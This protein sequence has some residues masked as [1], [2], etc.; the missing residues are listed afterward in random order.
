MDINTFYELRT[1]LYATAAAGCSLIE[2]DF[3][4]K[5]AL[6][7]FKP[8]SEANK[9]F[10]RLYQ[11]VDHLFTSDNVTGELMDCIALADALAVTQGSFLDKS[12][13]GEEPEERLQLEPQTISYK[14]VQQLKDAL[15]SGNDI[16]YV[17]KDL[18]R[19]LDPRI[20]L[21]FIK[22]VGRKTERH[23]E[24]ADCI[25]PKLNGNI[26]ELL[27]S[28][29]DVLDTTAKNKTSYYVRLISKLYG[30]QENGWYLSLIEHEEY[31]KSIRV[32]AILALTC[33]D[34]NAEKLLELYKTEKAAIKKEVLLALAELNPPEAED[35][36]TGMAKK[37][38]TS[39]E[40]M[41]AHSKHDIWA[42]FVREAFFTFI[43]NCENDSKGD[44]EVS[45]EMFWIF[46]IIH[47]KYQLADCFSIFAEKYPEIKKRNAREYIDWRKEM[48]LVLIENLL[49]QDVRY[50]ELIKNVYEA[51]KEFYFPARFF[52]ALKENGEEAFT[53]YQEEI[54]QDRE[55]V[56]EMLTYVRYSH[57]SNCY[58]M[59]WR[60]IGNNWGANSWRI[61]DENDFPKIKIFEK[62]PKAMI[63]YLTEW[64]Y[65]AHNGIQNE[66][67]DGVIRNATQILDPDRMGYMPCTEEYESYKDMA[68][69]YAFTVNRNHS[70]LTEITWIL[71]KHY[72]TGTPEEYMEIIRNHELQ[73][74]AKGEIS[75]MA[76]SLIN[77]FP[78]TEEE[79]EKV[80][81]TL[82]C[83]VEEFKQISKQN[84]RRLLDKIDR[85]LK[86]IHR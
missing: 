19:I 81:Q 80:L 46:K 74:V 48:N 66:V 20:F 79:Q 76:L 4:L 71:K 56:F 30:Y 31:P 3:R 82:R 32:A 27:K 73:S 69:Q 75:G 67:T 2:E 39:Y 33:S 5:R 83:E 17:Q 13:C 84:K 25:L 12:E 21:T 43:K 50:A 11:M 40:D 52:L 14:T 41:V 57:I 68:I 22:G 24:L 15:L 61:V 6:E 51:H 34:N 54:R 70:V 38:K 59:Y 37:Y 9:V 49:D 44:G 35:L 86:F 65:F 23:K 36:W 63:S 64:D 72:T 18:Q 28:Q 8:M 29:V 77:Q 10:G 45:D 16:T 42:E 60:C 58:Y 78:L 53:I 55:C 7:A 47:K 26:A 62:M 85:M 1:R